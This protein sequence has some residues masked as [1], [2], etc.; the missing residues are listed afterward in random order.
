[1]IKQMSA[2]KRVAACVQ[3]FWCFTFIFQVRPDTGY[4]RTR[5]HMFTV[6]TVW[7]GGLGR[8]HGS[9]QPTAVSDALRHITACVSLPLLGRLEPSAAVR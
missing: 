4:R 5:V 2:R 7:E 8:L 3:Q 6:L 1:M 9:P